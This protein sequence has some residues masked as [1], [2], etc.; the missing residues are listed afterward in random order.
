MAESE[1]FISACMP[2]LIKE[3][4]ICIEKIHPKVHPSRIDSGL[5]LLR[6]E[7][8]TCTASRFA[9]INWSAWA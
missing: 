2:L 4:N 9:A 6:E 3:I 1:G 7:R 5:V 8:G